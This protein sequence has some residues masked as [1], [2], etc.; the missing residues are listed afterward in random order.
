MSQ[1]LQPRLSGHETF[2]C[3]FAWLPKVVKELNSTDEGANLLFR[4]ENLAMVKLGV[5]K[6][7]VRS[8][9]FWAEIAGIIE[10]LT[11]GGHSV[12]EFGDRILGYEGHDPYLERQETLWLLH[13]KISTST[14]PVYYWQQMLNFW[15]RADFSLSEIYPFLERG[16][17]AN[18]QSR[19]KRTIGDGFKVFI[20]TYVPTR[21]RKGEIKEDNLDCPLV[22]LGL[23][24]SA[25]SRTDTNSGKNELIYSF[26][27]DDKPDVTNALFAYC[28]NDYWGKSHHTGETL[29]FR[30]ISSGEGSPG[31]IFKLPELAIRIKFEQLQEASI[32][33]FEFMESS[34]IQQIVRQQEVESIALLDNIY[35]SI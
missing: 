28:I 24:K 15:H 27:F 17:P 2:A 5:G 18:T 22:E 4:D 7:M 31:Q 16:L 14:P 29:D 6:N 23:I 33:A 20:H 13:W 3:R 12:T 35:I 11:T 30:S 21:G 10:P 1:L 34:T 8:I 9:R 32:G 26:N 19:S 25:G